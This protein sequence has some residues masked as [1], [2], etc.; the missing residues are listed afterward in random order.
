MLL[1]Q[2]N[3]KRLLMARQNE[4]TS[5]WHPPYLLPGFGPN[6]SMAAKDYQLQ[7]MLLE[8]QNQ[9]RLAMARQEHDNIAGHSQG[10]VSSVMLPPNQ[11]FSNHQIQSDTIKVASSTN[12]L[13]ERDTN[14]QVNHICSIQYLASNVQVSD[15]IG[16][17][18]FLVSSSDCSF[19]STG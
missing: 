2:Q 14:E 15:F 1:E 5:E 17:E 13:V 4:D 6:Q 12:Q 16:E 18:G 8:Q 11:N 9:K 7:S 10:L 19:L 3:K